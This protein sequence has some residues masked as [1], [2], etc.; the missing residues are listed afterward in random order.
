[1]LG[2]F[3]LVMGHRLSLTRIEV[4]GRGIANLPAPETRVVQFLSPRVARYLGLMAK[5]IE[6][7]PDGAIAVVVPAADASLGW[8]TTASQ[9]RRGAERK[10]N[11]V[12]EGEFLDELIDERATRNPDFPRM[13][14]SYY[15]RRLA[16][17]L[18]EDSVFRM[19]FERQRQKIA[20]GQDRPRRGDLA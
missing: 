19:E 14:E 11:E 5:V 3:A 1:M 7:R 20:A 18:K 2:A 6:K 9:G 12:P 13:V 15:D 17:R 16:R 10:E 8:T 4:L